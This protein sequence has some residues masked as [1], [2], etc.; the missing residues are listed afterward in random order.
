ML[1]NV[2]RIAVV[3][4]LLF[5]AACST[6]DEMDLL[7]EYL[8]AEA[9]VAGAE[10]EDVDS[11]QA[12]IDR[13]LDSARSNLAVEPAILNTS[14]KLERGAQ[15]TATSK[16]S[17][18]DAR[19][20]VLFKE[21]MQDRQPSSIA[22]EKNTASNEQMQRLASAALQGSTNR[23]PNRSAITD[24]A[25]INAR[26]QL[27]QAIEKTK[28]SGGTPLPSADSI[29]RQTASISAQDS[30]TKTQRPSFGFIRFEGLLPESD[31]TAEA[32]QAFVN[33]T[34]NVQRAGMEIEIHVGL[35]RRG[36][37]Y[38]KLLAAQKTFDRL[39]MIAPS[40]VRISPVFSPELAMSTVEVHA[41]PSGN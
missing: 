33:F 28:S 14:S 5:L 36:S 38:D 18:T 39:R 22:F 40:S 27:L 8:R 9:K 19:A 21:F 20:D 41:K 6:P 2:E 13:M 16:G 35:A 7:P 17:S 1:R 24:P 3:T 26:L 23:N 30:S 25:Q 29:P 15:D 12:A 34:D 4:F 37:A 10:G 11:A 31:L 32:K